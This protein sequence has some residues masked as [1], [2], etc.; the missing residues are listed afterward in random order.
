MNLELAGK[1]ALVTGGSQ[2]IGKAIARTLAEEG[3]KVAI[4][5]RNASVLEAA[6]A[7]IEADTG[8]P[9]HAVVADVSSRSEVD[10]MVADVATKFGRLDILVNNAGFPGGL[11]KGPLQAIDDDRVLEDLNVKY[12][13]YLRCARAAV[14]HMQRHGWGRLIHIGGYAGLAHSAYSTGARA[15]AI[16]HLSRILASELGGDNITSNVIHPGAT[17][18]ERFEEAARSRDAENVYGRWIEPREVA[19]VVAFIASPRSSALTGQTIGAG[20]AARP[21]IFM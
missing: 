10:A 2:G 17:R 5:A 7:S 8:A 4:C 19:D 13:G 3:V 1:V 20:G 16:I 12:L 11:E 9:V 6:A 21:A 15:M 14:P 18:T